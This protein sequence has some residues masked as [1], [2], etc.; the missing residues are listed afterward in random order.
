VRAT[1]F[2]NLSILAGSEAAECFNVP[3]PWSTGL[4]Q[5]VLRDAIAEAGDGFDL[6]LIDCPL[7]IQLWAWS[8]LVAAQ[9]V[10]VPLQ[11]EDYGAQGL[12]AIRRSIARVR[13]E[14]NAHLALVGY[15]VTMFNKALS[16]H[17]TYDAYLR[18]L[19][20]EDVFATVVPLAKDFKEAITFRKPVIEHKP[21]SA[22][23]WVCGAIHRGSAGPSTARTGRGHSSEGS[24]SASLNCACHPCFPLWE[25]RVEPWGGWPRMLLGWM[26]PDAITEPSRVER[27]Q[28]I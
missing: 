11:A 1:P 28:W 10:L 22:V 17:I 6:V 2:P 7:H 15:L 19:Y 26:A 20:G 13:T 9:G 18:E 27:G 24:G 23:G 14:A 21:R 16:V 3:N 5:Y 25:T 4:R 8:A 12:K